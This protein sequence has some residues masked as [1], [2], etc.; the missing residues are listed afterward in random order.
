MVH[1]LLAAMLAA[2]VTVAEGGI[3]FQPALSPDGKQVAFAADERGV[4][5]IYVAPTDGSGARTKVTTIGRGVEAQ[6]LAMHALMHAPWSSDGKSLLFLAPSPDQKAERLLV[7]R[8]GEG[9]PKIVGP[10]AGLVENASFTSSGELVY[11]FRNDRYSSECTIYSVNLASGEAATPVMRFTDEA[12]ALDMAPSPDGRYLAVLCL[13]SVPNAH[14][15]YERDER[16]REV[17]MVDLKKAGATT[18]VDYTD[19]ANFLT[20]S[21]DGKRLYFVDQK[22]GAA[23]AIPAGVNALEP[24]LAKGLSSV[25]DAAGVLVGLEKSGLLVSIHPESGAV[26]PLSHGFAP[27]SVA[28]GKIA[29]MRLGSAGA[30]IVVTDGTREAIE[31]GDL[32]LTKPPAPPPPAPEKPADAPAP[33]TETPPANGGEKSGPG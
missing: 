12:A 27:I 2:A 26:K 7:A 9:D 13:Y 30:A 11:T 32:G 24:P 16:R 20:W 1:P 31:S 4:I 18:R 23:H 19:H 29:F 8:L 25:V 3:F 28:G 17:R 15:V 5:S 33:P 10:V 6:R 21:A 14:G 22:S